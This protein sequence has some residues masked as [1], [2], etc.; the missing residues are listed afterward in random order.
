[1]PSNEPT[2][3]GLTRVVSKCRQDLTEELPHPGAASPGA[4]ASSTSG[5][6]LGGGGGEIQVGT[7]AGKTK[8]LDGRTGGN[9][10]FI[11]R[12]HSVEGSIYQ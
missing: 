3:K 2:Y 7:S 8:L 11:G 5:C 6:S 1:M 9:E 4:R 10:T 12:V